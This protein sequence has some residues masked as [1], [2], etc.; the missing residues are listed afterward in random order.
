M[1][2]QTAL[3]AAAMGLAA[4]AAQQAAP[5]AV[6]APRLP[7]A[8]ACFPATPSAG[9]GVADP[10]RLP[11]RAATQLNADGKVLYREGRWD[12]AR[13]KYR[14]AEA[15]DPEFLAPALN[16]ACSFVRQERFAEATAEVKRILE[17]AYVPWN[18]EVLSAA[19]LGAL[20]VRPEMKEIRAALDAGRR[21]WSEGLADDVLFVARTRPALGLG[22]VPIGVL[23]LGPRQ[24]I[25][26]WSAATGRYRQ[27]TTEEG[28]VLALA[29]SADGRRIA[30]VTAEKLVR[31]EGGRAA[32]RGV[33]VTELDLAT[34][35]PSVRAPLGGGDITQLTVAARGPR[36][37]V[38]GV[39]RDGDSEALAASGERLVLAA[40]PLGRRDRV[41]VK[42]TGQ[43]VAPLAGGAAP[44]IP[45]ACQGTVRDG[46]S[47]SGTPVVL[48]KPSGAKAAAIP[49][50]GPFGAGLGGL[51]LP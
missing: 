27:L 7:S 46:K 31:R 20:K 21:R 1:I 5:Q 15:A 16:V 34:L 42:L 39:N 30:Y 8:A 37:F 19:D 41:L 40:A 48:V 51:P 2:G 47:G 18:A 28:R 33:V 3:A 10:F 24:E 14:A 38:Y 43:G 32:L 23:V 12:D 49:I 13:A 35:L 11:A 50:G 4:T 45:G 25:F 26:A 6:A 17:R 22:G 9:P 29:R 44:P 36:A